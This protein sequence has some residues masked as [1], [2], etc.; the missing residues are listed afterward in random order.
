ME[1]RIKPSIVGV[2]QRVFL[3]YR[4]IFAGKKILVR[5]NK[6][7]HRAVRQHWSSKKSLVGDCGIPKVVQVLR[8]LLDEGVFELEA[9]ADNDIL[10]LSPKPPQ[11]DCRLERGGAL[12]T[13]VGASGKL[14]ASLGRPIKIE[15]EGID[16]D[17]ERQ[18]QGAFSST[19]F[20]IL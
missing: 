4:D 8:A 18:G 9:Q 14:N 19:I 11:N 16:E 1:A 7:I 3:A 12:D 5:K 10:N 6:T 17:S 20:I 15:C 2:R 13:A